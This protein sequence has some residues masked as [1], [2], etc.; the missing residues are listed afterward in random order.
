M[1]YEYSLNQFMGLCQMVMASVNGQLRGR[2]PSAHELDKIRVILHPPG[3]GDNVTVSIGMPSAE[4]RKKYQ[5]TLDTGEIITIEA[6]DKSEAQTQAQVLADL[7]E[8]VVG[9]LERI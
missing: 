5:V 1:L 6:N 3:D 8:T 2:T 7:Y 4:M 9:E